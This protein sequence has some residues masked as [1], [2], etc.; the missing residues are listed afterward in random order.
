MP[1]ED[2]ALSARKRGRPRS[3]DVDRA[4]RLA[5]LDLLAERGIEGLSMEGIAARARVGKATVYRRWDRKEAVVAAAVAS[6][7]EQIEIPDTG[8]VEQDLLMLERDAVRL[9][10]GRAGRLV[11]GVI[12]LLARDEG[13]ARSF[14][15]GFLEERRRALRSV[16]ERAVAR[17]EL[18]RDADLELAL[19]FL[20][21]PLF[22]RLLVTGG[23]LDEGLVRGVVGVLL[24]GLPGP[25]PPGSPSS[26]RSI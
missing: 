15:E 24:H 2:V 1:P 9:Y 3:E 16:L 7:V 25:D 21:G 19:D 8:S 5:V 20:G 14:R 18:G 10:R 13:F 6:L 23:V 26:G 12:A 4:I 17:G 11:P 22:Y